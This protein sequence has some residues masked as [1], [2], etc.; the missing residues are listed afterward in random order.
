MSIYTEELN[1]IFSMPTKIIFGAGSIAELKN[2]IERRGLKKVLVVTDKILREKTDIVKRALE[3][4]GEKVAGV[5]DEV[6]PDSG[7]HIVNS[8]GR[9][10]RELKVDCIVS[11]GGGS[12][13]DT[14]KGIAILNAHGGKITDYDGF[15]VLTERVTPHIVVPTTAG[16]GSEVTM[17]AVIKDHDAKR[18]LIFGD[19]HIIP[20]VAILDP[21]LTIGLPPEMTAATGMDALSHCVE[22]M[23]SQQREPFADA[24]ALH[25][26][27]LITKYL[28]IAYR[29]GGDLIARGQLLIAACIAGVAF[30]NAQVG[31][32]H[33][34]AH[35]LGAKYGIPHGVANALFLPYVME[36]NLPE[37]LEVYMEIARALGIKRGSLKK[38]EYAKKAIERI[39][40]LVEELSLPGR[41]RDLGVKREDLVL[42]AEEALGDGCIVYNPRF[43]MDTKEIMKVL[44][45]A[46]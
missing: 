3:I 19:I 9:V 37:C 35:V 11:I 17:A 32:V 21:E 4:M 7:V 14:G 20:D 36:F 12:V 5:F 16:T 34:L 43:A 27:K 30:S 26:I 6:V 45:T 33:A 22:A 23:H 10:A 40:S 31:L 28:P 42:M 46:Y 18:K 39:R 44:E 15:N 1:F 29:N 13:I 38:E 24:L 25:G 41:L 2:E 8:G